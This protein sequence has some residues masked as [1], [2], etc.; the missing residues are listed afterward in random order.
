[1]RSE[2]KYFFYCKAI[3]L[4]KNH[5]DMPKVTQAH[6]ATVCGSITLAYIPATMQFSTQHIYY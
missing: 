6:S 3:N 4:K 1:M 5:N 2:K